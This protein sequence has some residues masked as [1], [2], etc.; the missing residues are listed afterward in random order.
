MREKSY[1]QHFCWPSSRRAGPW[2]GSTSFSWTHLFIASFATSGTSKQMEQWK[3]CHYHYVAHFLADQVI[4][5][6]LAAAPL[7][8]GF[9]PCD[10]TLGR[11]EWDHPPLTQACWGE[12]LCAGTAVRMPLPLSWNCRQSQNTHKAPWMQIGQLASGYV[13]SCCPAFP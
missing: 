10:C 4:T 12:E 3:V 7:L 11:R 9:S 8:P 1:S 2:G 5:S 6:V 13:A